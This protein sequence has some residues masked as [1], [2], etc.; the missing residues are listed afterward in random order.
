MPRILHPLRVA[1][2][3]TGSIFAKHRTNCQ[4]ITQGARLLASKSLL[5]SLLLM[6]AGHSGYASAQDNVG[7]G[8]T[9]IYPASYFVDYRPVT[10]QDMLNRIPGMSGTGGSSRGPSSGGG[11]S[12]GGRGFGGGS[13]N[14]ILINGKRVAGKNNSQDLLGRVSADQVLQ[15]EIIRGTSGELD[16]RGSSQII[17]V[18]LFEQMSNAN[19][20]FQASMDQYSDSESKPGGSLSYSGQSGALNY[21]INASAE[22][23]YRHRVSREQSILGDFSPNDLVLENRTTQQTDYS[24]STNLGYDINANSSIR[25]NALFQQ[26]DNPTDVFRETTDLSNGSN[27]V[28]RE[29]EIIPGAQD[30]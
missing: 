28:Y 22:P 21:L 13:G 14:Q 17:N 27:S 11:A 1:T 10:A 12:R 18:V 23:R 25:L 3:L 5:L 2:F 6:V 26:K 15:I 9:V 7:D 24:L 19:I 29:Q 8:S 20:S 4:T 16:V 30:N